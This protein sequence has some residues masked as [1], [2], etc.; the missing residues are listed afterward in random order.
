M[1]TI[2]EKHT[3]VTKRVRVLVVAP[4]FDILGGQA[5]QAARLIARLREVDSFAVGFLAINPRLP[6]VLRALQA[7]KYL[8]TLVTSVLYFITLFAQIPRYDVIHVFSASYF[9]F[10]LA[11][12]PAILI[13]KL[14]RKRVLLNYHS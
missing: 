7:I 3:D 1:I 4:S 10:L 8:R 14:F 9:S 2:R 13:G 5:V 12:T 11:P 6:G